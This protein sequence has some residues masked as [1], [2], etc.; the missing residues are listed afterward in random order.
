MK[1]KY[2]SLILVLSLIF[3]SSV[4]AQEEDNINLDLGLVEV[5]IDY[6]T[7]EIT[8][9]EALVEYLRE[10]ISGFEIGEFTN[11]G[12]PPPLNFED[13][14][15]QLDMLYGDLYPVNNWFSG[16]H[17]YNPE[18]NL[19]KDV[20]ENTSSMVFGEPHTKDINGN[21]TYLGYVIDPITHN[22]HLV[23]N[24]YRPDEYGDGTSIIDGDWNLVANP[25]NRDNLINGNHSYLE[26][27][28]KYNVDYDNEINHR[29]EQETLENILISMEI[30]R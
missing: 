24:H 4:I 13:T 6:M 29:A 20:F 17:N 28:V 7:E 15:T 18:H 9:K 30:H 23:L 1:T 16:Y 26:E 25:W 27:V 12:F 11:R 10:Q 21:D 14:I 8:T 2:F 22:T 3:S 5:N 19:N